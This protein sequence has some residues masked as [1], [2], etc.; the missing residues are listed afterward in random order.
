MNDK[1]EMTPE[2][3]KKRRDKYAERE[4]LLFLAMC[5]KRDRKLIEGE[6]N[7]TIEDFD[8]IGYLL[9][10]LGFDNFGWNFSFAHKEL[11]KELGDKI[12]S[13]VE[14][15]GKLD[16]NETFE[17]ARQWERDFCEGL[18]SDEMKKYIKR[19]FNIDE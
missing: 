4:K 6:E 1:F 14:T 2:L 11:L 8:R 7:L 5:S 17:T 12:E 9:E 3:I 16:L 18:S 19:I 13:E 10:S 15:P